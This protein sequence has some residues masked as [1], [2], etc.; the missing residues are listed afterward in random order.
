M[1]ADSELFPIIINYHALSKELD[2][3][4]DKD[5]VYKLIGPVLTKQDLKDAKENVGRRIEYINDEIKRH[6]G[7]I[8]DFEKK[9][10]A[11]KDVITAL[12]QKLQQ[13]PKTA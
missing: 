1:A 8:L 7:S 10:D 5:T 12:Q 11:Q 4:Q 3:L 2:L 9:Q 6:D 13:I